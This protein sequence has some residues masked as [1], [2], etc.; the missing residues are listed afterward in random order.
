MEETKTTKSSDFEHIGNISI[1]VKNKFVDKKVPLTVSIRR[2]N[3]EY[4]DNLSKVG[5]RKSEFVNALITLA[6]E[7]KIKVGQ[8]AC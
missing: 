7:N 3:E 2:S 6:K 1:K 5:T 4:L 8:I